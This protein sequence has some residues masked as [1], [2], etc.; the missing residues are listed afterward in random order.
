MPGAVVIPRSQTVDADD[1]GEPLSVS[2]AMSGNIVATKFYD[3]SGRPHT[4]IMFV[5]GGV[6]YSDPNGER[7]ASGLKTMSDAVADRIKARVKDSFKAQVTKVLEELG[8]YGDKLITS[9]AMD[10]VDILADE[11]DEE[12]ARKAVP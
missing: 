11:V 8:L 1:R 3:K 6:V 12:A 9:G 2:H 4:E 7:W 5:I 10:N